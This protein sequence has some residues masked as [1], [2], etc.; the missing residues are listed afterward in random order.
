MFKSGNLTNAESIS[1]FK[2]I[3]KVGTLEDTPLLSLLLAKG[4]TGK[5][6]GTVQT[7]RESSYSTEDIGS[8]VIE[9]NEQPKFYESGR[10]ELSN[11][12]QIFQRGASVSGTAQAI[13]VTGQGD[14]FSGEIADRLVEIRAGLENAITTGELKDGSITPFIRQLKGLENWVLPENVVENEALNSLEDDIKSTVR[15]LWEKGVSGTFFG[16]VNADLKEQIDSIYIDKYSYIADHNVFGLTVS[17]IKTNYG[18]LYFLLSRNASPDKLTVFDINQLAID[19]LRQPQFEA[20]A[21]VGDSIRG[22]VITE[23]TLRVK[24]PKA[25]AQLVVNEE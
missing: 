1:L 3:T 15:K 13:N 22:Q 21:K 24:T 11:V 25:I 17:G 9:G 7:W 8:G 10:A 16:L 23:A 14:I 2:E 6:N 20:L 4:L 18:T 12:L 5:A 19:F